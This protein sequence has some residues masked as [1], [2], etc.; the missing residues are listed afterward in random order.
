MA[1]G[2]SR[3]HRETNRTCLLLGSSEAHPDRFRGALKRVSQLQQAPVRTQRTDHLQ[4]NWQAGACGNAAR[5]GQR[6]VARQIEWRGK[7]GTEAVAVDF[8]S[9]RSFGSD[10]W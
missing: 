3:R 2:E 4:A 9:A 10:K 8:R 7:R 5:Y 6:G 1:W